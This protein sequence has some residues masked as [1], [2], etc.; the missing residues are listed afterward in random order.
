MV[1]RSNRILRVLRATALA[2]PARRRRPAT[3]PMHRRVEV[4]PLRVGVRI[5]GHL[6]SEAGVL[7][8]PYRLRLHLYAGRADLRVF[9]TFVFNQDPTRV[10]LK[11]IDFPSG[12][13][14]GLR[15]LAG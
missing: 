6:R 2:F 12:D 13:Q 10:E 8:C 7:F 3:L 14:A 1:E 15:S 9:H 4:G 11:A 5:D